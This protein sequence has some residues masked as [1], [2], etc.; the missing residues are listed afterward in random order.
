MGFVFG[1]IGAL[2]GAWFMSEGRTFFG[3]LVGMIIGWLMYRL[4]QAQSTI[5]RL[6]DRVDTLEQRNAATSPVE[7]LAKKTFDAPPRVSAYEPSEPISEPTPEPIS[8]S[9]PEPTTEPITE[10]APERTPEF[11][12]APEPKPVVHPRVPEAP[13]EPGMGAHA[14]EVAQ[15]WLTTGNVPVKGYL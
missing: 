13:P 5:R 9:T 12:P 1:L 3:F 11:K 8:K 4:S 14:I 6:G 2:A 10:S 15:R 7:K